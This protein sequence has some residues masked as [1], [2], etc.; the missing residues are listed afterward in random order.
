VAEIFDWAEGDCELTIEPLAAA[1]ATAATAATTAAVTASAEPAATPGGETRKGSDANYGH[2]DGIA[3]ATILGNGAVAL[4]LDVAGLT[5][6]ATG[7][8]AA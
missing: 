1:A 2:V 3:G 4:I 5:R 6:A 7:R 8:A